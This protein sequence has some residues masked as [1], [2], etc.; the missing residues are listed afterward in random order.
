MDWTNIVALVVSCITLLVAAVGTV[1]VYL[2]HRARK[3]KELPRIQLYE[4]VG[5]YH[6]RLDTDQRSIGWKVIRVEAVHSDYIK[7]IL[8]QTL[9]RKEE[10][11]HG[12]TISSYLSEWRNFCEYPEGAGPLTSIYFHDNCYEASLIFICETPSRVWWKPWQ[13]EKKKVP[14]KFVRGTHPPGHSDPYLASLLGHR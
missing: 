5:A 3:Q 9:Y 11:N 10:N 2:G 6:F 4:T 7:E 8:K 14:Y 13:M 1:L 12:V